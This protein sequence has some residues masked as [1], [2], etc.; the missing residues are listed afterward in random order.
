MVPGPRLLAYALLRQQELRQLQQLCERG[1]RQAAR[2]DGGHGR[3]EGPPRAGQEGAGDHHGRGALDLHRLPELQ[4]GP[5]GQSPRLD[6]LHLEQH[7]LSGLQPGLIRRAMAPDDSR[8]ARAGGGERR[9]AFFLAV[10]RTH[11]S[12]AL[13]YAIVLTVLL[14]AASA[15]WIAPYPPET[16]DP[17]AFLQPPGWPHVMGTD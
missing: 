13:G 8:T 14:L 2:R 11:P 1:G 4:H 9:L 15:P 7:P 16:A 12:F 6:L 5:E 17:A 10:L 3:R